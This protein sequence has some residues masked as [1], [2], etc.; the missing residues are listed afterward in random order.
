MVPPQKKDAHGVVDQVLVTVARYQHTGRL[1][2]VNEE[3]ARIFSLSSQSHMGLSQL[4][5]MLLRRGASAHVAMH[6]GDDLPVPVAAKVLPL[7]PRQVR[8]SSAIA[9]WEDEGGAWMP[10]PRPS[11][12]H[13][14]IGLAGLRPV[15]PAISGQEFESA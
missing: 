4:Q 12:R 9:R 10:A 6:V 8:R 14:V 3:A 15:A 7:R 1:M 11:D 2:N 13:H 5:E